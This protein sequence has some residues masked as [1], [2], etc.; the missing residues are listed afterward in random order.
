MCE[1]NETKRL[2]SLKADALRRREILSHLS[3]PERKL[4]RMM[5][6]NSASPCG[7]WCARLVKGPGVAEVYCVDLVLGT[8]TE[9]HSALERLEF[10]CPKGLF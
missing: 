2:E 4:H 3:G 1:C 7:C 6:C 5:V 10:E 8:K 9:L